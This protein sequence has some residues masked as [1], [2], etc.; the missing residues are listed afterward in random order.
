MFSFVNL[1]QGLLEL[2]LA[3]DVLVEWSG[4]PCLP[5]PYNWDWIQCNSEVKPRVIAL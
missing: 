2:Q 4:D 3:F 5:N 1:V